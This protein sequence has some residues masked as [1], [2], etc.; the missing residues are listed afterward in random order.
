LPQSAA[1]CRNLPQS[2]AICRNL[3]QSAAKYGDNAHFFQTLYKGSVCFVD[4]F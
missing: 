4:G 1:I 2:A 3:P